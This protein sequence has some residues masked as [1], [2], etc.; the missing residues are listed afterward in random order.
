ML[1]AHPSCSADKRE[2][3]CTHKMKSKKKKKEVS[4][5]RFSKRERERNLP[6]LDIHR[7]IG[8][9]LAAGTTKSHFP[10]VNRFLSRR[11]QRNAEQNSADGMDT[12]G[13][14]CIVD[15]LIRSRDEHV[16]IEWPSAESYLGLILI[17]SIG[18][19]I[20]FSGKYRVDLG[21]F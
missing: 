13:K 14:V 19:K 4:R 3:P 8:V 7:S 10:E 20:Y 17:D 18:D 2:G 12:H 5:I 9:T 1:S 6:L 16:A 11:K 15:C 21:C